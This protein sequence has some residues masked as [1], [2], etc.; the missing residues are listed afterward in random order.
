MELVDIIDENGNLTGEVLDKKEA[1][2]KKKLH[3]IVACFIIDGKGKILLQLR[4]KKKSLA[5]EKIGTV[6]GHVKSKED[7]SSAIIREL[8]EEIGLNVRNDEVKPIGEKELAIREK[9][10]HILNFY[11]L[12]KEINIEELNINKEEV[13]SVKWYDL[14]EIID[15]INNLDPRLNFG[16]EKLTLFDELKKL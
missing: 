5:A 4:S 15:M 16:K 13:E 1:H 10:A 7:L 14:D 3:N 6:A 9:E 8:N 12:L 2:E 11:Y